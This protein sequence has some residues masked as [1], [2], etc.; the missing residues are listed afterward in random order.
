V[1]IIAENRCRI[2]TVD[3]FLLNSFCIFQQK[4]QSRHT[5]V[6]FFKFVH[7]ICF[8]LSYLPRLVQETLELCYSTGLHALFNIT[9]YIWAINGVSCHGIKEHYKGIVLK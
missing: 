6:I 5:D 9:V 7:S 8:P 1:S 2:H 4:L 3:S